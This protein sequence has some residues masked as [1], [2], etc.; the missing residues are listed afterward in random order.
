[1]CM[2]R[3]YAYEYASKEIVFDPPLWMAV[4]IHGWRSFMQIVCVPTFVFVGNAQSLQ[5]SFYSH[6][7]FIVEISC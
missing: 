5:I 6:G 7:L 2:R 3:L 4:W 1:M